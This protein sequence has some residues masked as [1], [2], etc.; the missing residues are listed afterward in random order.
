M[1]ENKSK[2]HDRTVY[3]GL[4]NAVKKIDFEVSKI[5]KWNHQ[6][7]T[8]AAVYINRSRNN[9]KHRL[10]RINTKKK[11]NDSKNSD[12]NNVNDNINIRNY[13]ESDENDFDCNYS[14]VTINVGDS[15]IVLARGPRA[16]DLTTDH[17]PNMR[18]RNCQ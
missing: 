13:E 10:R 3:S 5:R 15:R 11:E 12:K 2:W 18:Q 16:I 14:I 4:K 6:G 1:P 7:S 8:L 17:K 9:S